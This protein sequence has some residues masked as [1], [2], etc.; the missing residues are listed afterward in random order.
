MRR[1][2]LSTAFALFFVLS[3]AMPVAAQLPPLKGQPSAPPAEPPPPD[4]SHCKA[5]L[6]TIDTLRAQ[7]PPDWS[8]AVVNEPVFNADVLVMQAGRMNAQTVLLVHGLG[9][10]GF[11]DWL[12]VIPRLA[13]SHHV[14]AVDL[15][16]FGY[17]SAPPG[18][19][20]PKNYARLLQWLLAAHGKGPAIVIG[21]SMGGA[22]SLRLAS[23]HPAHVSRLVLVDA[24][25]I[26]H[27]MAFVKHTATVPVN[28]DKVHPLL[29][30]PAARA[31]DYGNAVVERL[32]GLAT[33]PVRVLG[34]SELAWGFLLRDRANVNAGLALVEEDFSAAVHT[35][36]QPTHVI[37]GEDD[38]VAPLRTG[39]LLAARLPRATLHTLPATG[40]VPMDTATDSFL[41][42][43]SFAL[44]SD[45]APA[46][47]PAAA[48][49]PARDLRCSGLVDREYRGHYREIVIDRCTAIRL[50][51]VSAQRI[52]IRDSSVVMHN[53]AVAGDE[54][55]LDVTNSEVVG[56]AGDLR[57]AVAIRAD[58]S[59]LD[60]AGYKIAATSAV[61][62]VKRRSRVIASISEVRSPA[63]T[64]YWHDTHDVEA[65]TLAPGTP[66]TA[67]SN[68]PSPASAGQGPGGFARG[69]AEHCSAPGER[70]AACQP[71]PRTAGEG[72]PVAAQ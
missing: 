9:Q 72:R 25:G 50:R 13:Q 65:T 36:R 14:I 58:A 33:D 61:A 48:A 46:E 70:A 19:Y 5:K 2:L 26:L 68:L 40:H 55:A 29:K 8:L 32:F 12:K 54:V 4:C 17:S 10:N 66:A 44:D 59:R 27:R 11:T 22:V 24:A 37:W 57:A 63:Y 7:L 38:P 15:P 51:D 52:V 30:E 71:Q 3:F 18:K 47:P 69:F 42:L 43:L 34:Q 56:T 1:S 39:Q 53:V 64:G 35:L 20:S 16:G 31:K 6:K 62:E 49:A 23:D 41:A 45:P 60:L 21:H 28:V 67:A